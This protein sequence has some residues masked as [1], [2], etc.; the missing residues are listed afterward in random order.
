MLT[1][2]PVNKPN[3]REKLLERRIENLQERIRELER[4]SLSSDVSPFDD[5]TVTNDEKR[6]SVLVLPVTYVPVEDNS[7]KFEIVSAPSRVRPQSH[8]PLLLVQQSKIRMF[9]TVV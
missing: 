7:A 3:Q 6:S 1:F 8:V 4:R 5:R 2:N 9:E